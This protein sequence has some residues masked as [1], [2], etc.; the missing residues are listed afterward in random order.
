MKKVSIARRRIENLKHD[1]FDYAAPSPELRT[2]PFPKRESPE[3]SLNSRAEVTTR[4]DPS[5]SAEMGLLE[6]ELD[7]SQT[8]RIEAKI[9]HGDMLLSGTLGRNARGMILLNLE[10]SDDRKSKYVSA[11]T[12][13]EMLEICPKTVYRMHRSGRLPGLRIGRSLRFSFKE[14]LEFLEA[15]SEERE[16]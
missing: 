14:V 16:G 7:S 5:R 1:Y 10:T 8:T 13:S 3:K 15:C 9:T 2:L 6:V 11:R 12:I 4:R